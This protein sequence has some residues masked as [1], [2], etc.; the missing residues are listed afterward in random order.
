MRDDKNKMTTYKI[1]DDTT[2]DLLAIIRYD[3][4]QYTSEMVKHPC[5]MMLFASLTNKGVIWE[6]DPNPVSEVLE[7]FLSDRVLPPNRMFIEKSLAEVGL[8]R[9]DWKEM[10]KLNHGRTVSDPY[11][12]EVIE[13]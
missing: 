7:N 8:Y 3:G 9:Y 1:Y 12:V 2:K 5:K 11:S 6:G 4:K 10:I 13:E